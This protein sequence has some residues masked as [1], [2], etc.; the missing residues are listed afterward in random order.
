MESKIVDLLKIDYQNTAIKDDVII[1]FLK[2]GVYWICDKEYG[3]KESNNI[4]C[5]SVKRVFG[6]GKKQVRNG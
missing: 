4:N 2:S 1:V 3:V 5:Y 6:A